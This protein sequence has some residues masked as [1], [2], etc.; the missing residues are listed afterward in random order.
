MEIAEI[1]NLNINIYSQKYLGN[2]SLYSKRKRVERPVGAQEKIEVQKDLSEKI[3]ESIRTSDSQKYNQS[4]INS[5]IENIIGN[6]GG[7][8][9]EI[10]N[11]EDYIKAILSVVHSKDKKAKYKVEVTDETVNSVEYSFPKIIYRR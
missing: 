1:F 10:N 2:T 11:D 4:A 7:I 8:L 6:Y 5:Y 3:L 9:T